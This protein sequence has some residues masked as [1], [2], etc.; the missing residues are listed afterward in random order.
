M[1]ETGDILGLSPLRKLR[2]LDAGGTSITEETHRL[3]RFAYIGDAC[4]KYLVKITWPQE[5][6]VGILRD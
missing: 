3:V 4:R 1:V 2:S 5:L 6:Y